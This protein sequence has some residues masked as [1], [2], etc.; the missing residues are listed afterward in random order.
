[1]QTSPSYALTAK[2]E[3]LERVLTSAIFVAAPFD[4]KVTEPS[5][6]SKR[7]YQAIWDTGATGCVISPKVATDLGLIPIGLNEIHHGGGA[8][9][10]PVHLVSLFLS[11]KVR[12]P[13]IPVTQLNIS[14]S[15]ILI[16]MDV[17]NKGDFAVSNLNGKTSFT[18]RIPSLKEV[19]FIAEIKQPANASFPAVSRN[20][21]CPCGSG[22]KYKKCH[23]S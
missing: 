10:A 8:E 23:G 11:Q 3:K 21:P 20:D 16:G 5:E 18:F 6:G 17:I 13:Q 15:D 12:F 2:S 4:P 9:I 1:V 7:K 19:D 22:K 14:G